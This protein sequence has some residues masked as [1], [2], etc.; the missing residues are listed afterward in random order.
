MKVWTLSAT[1]IFARDFVL[2]DDD[3]NKIE[4]VISADVSM[5]AKEVTRIVIEIAPGAATIKGVMD[6]FH[7][8][9]PNCGDLV[10]H[11]CEKPL[12]NP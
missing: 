9:C 5:A 3:G 11:E 2:I 1:D 6:G 10:S 12:G 8:S 4:G 7:T